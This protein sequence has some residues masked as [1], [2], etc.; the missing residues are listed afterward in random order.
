MASIVQWQDLFVIVDDGRVTINEYERLEPLV[1]VQAKGCPQGLGCLVIIP[2]KADPPTSAVRHH[3]EG[4]LGRLQ[5]RSLAY[6]V[7]GS[8][9]R[10]ATARGAL[11]GLGIFQRKRYPTKVFT[12]LVTALEWLLTAPKEVRAAMKVIHESR[13]NANGN[14]HQVAVQMSRGMSK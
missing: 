6:L 13:T 9:F 14:D 10:A 11:I 4:M 5:I 1:R 12:T 3:L 8:G 2:E 7:E